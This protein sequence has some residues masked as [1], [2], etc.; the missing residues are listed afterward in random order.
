MKYRVGVAVGLIA[1]ILYFD[2]T[3]EYYQQIMG[4]FD[5]ITFWKTPETVRLI[6]PIIAIIISFTFSCLIFGNQTAVM[7]TF[8]RS[9]TKVLSNTMCHHVYIYIYIYIYI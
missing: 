4:Y 7:R 5:V 9:K 6:A 2:L 1:T 3:K 8:S